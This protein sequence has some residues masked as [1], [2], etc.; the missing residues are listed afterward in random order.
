MTCL[1][2]RSAR[3]SVVLFL[4]LASAAWLPARGTAERGVTGVPPAPASARYPEYLSLADG[5]HVTGTPVEVDAESYRLEVGG[6][7]AKPLRLRLDEVRALPRERLLMSL[8]CPGF[9]TDEGTW[10]GV[11]LAEIL[12]LAGYQSGARA[13]EFTSIDKKYTQSLTLAE[14]L[15]DSVL[16]AYQF[17]DRDF[18]VYHG[19][20]L[21]LAAG[22][23]P[24]SVWVKW[25]GS[26]T[27]R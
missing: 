18:P 15:S 16:V 2:S 21:R 1:R 13:V 22:G 17:D 6:L 11:R 27:V 12:R 26:I 14:A 23:Q 3:G 19:F 5:L 4:M 8:N 7:V 25:L 10:T 9:F 24:G 20:P